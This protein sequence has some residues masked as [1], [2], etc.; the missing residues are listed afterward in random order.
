MGYIFKQAK[1]MKKVYNRYIKTELGCPL[2]GGE[3]F[4]TML[5]ISRLLRVIR[6]IYIM[7]YRSFF[8]GR[9]TERGGG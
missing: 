1:G 9:A 6:Y 8:S 2:K 7:K 3:H 5:N 4:A